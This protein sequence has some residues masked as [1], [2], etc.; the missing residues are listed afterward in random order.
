MATNDE[1][2]PKHGGSGS[3]ELER[4]VTSVET[5]LGVIEK[6]MVTAEVLQ[7]ELGALRREIHEG[8]GALRNE[9]HA[10]PVAVRGEIAKMPFETVK[11]LLAV[12]GIAA[13]ITM[14]VYTIWFR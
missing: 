12:F 4:R 1:T 14:T 2:P 11:W 7:R 10:E 13:A 8:F 5:R 6:T 9:M 3:R